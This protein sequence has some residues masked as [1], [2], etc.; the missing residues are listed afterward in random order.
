MS[1]DQIRLTKGYVAFF[2]ILGYREMTNHTNFKEI[3]KVLRESKADAEQ[4]FL[5]GKTKYELFTFGD[6]IIVFCP[7]DPLRDESAA[8]LPVYLSALFRRMFV[9]GMPVRGAVA[10]G[11]YYFKERSYAGQPLNEAYEYANSLE[12]SG[13]VLTPSAEDL[14]QD[15]DSEISPEGD[16]FFKEV[17]IPL[18][19]QGNQKLFVLRQI[20]RPTR[21]EVVKAFQ[22]HGKSITPA[23]LPKLN[24]TVRILEEVYLSRKVPPRL[25]KQAISHSITQPP[26]NSH[27]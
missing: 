2:D 24:N 11:Q 12:F 1:D 20:I 16:L 26:S 15:P 25:K 13:C 23:V 18:K 27:A 8:R 5:S 22:K 21:E 19:N 4:L 3:I 6:S 17:S 7:G 10:K 9:R 14:V